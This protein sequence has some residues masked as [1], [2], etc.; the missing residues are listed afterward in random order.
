[1]VCDLKSCKLMS[2]QMICS[3]SFLYALRRW[4]MI[5]FTIGEPLTF[6]D[7]TTRFVPL[8]TVKHTLPLSGAY[9]LY[10]VCIPWHNIGNIILRYS[11]EMY[12][13]S[14]LV[15]YLMC[16]GYLFSPWKLASMASVRGVNVPM[17]TTLRRTTVVFTM[18]MEYIMAGQRYTSPVVG[19]WP[20]YCIYHLYV[21][22]L[23]LFRIGSC[24]FNV[25]HSPC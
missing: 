10:M 7:N 9:L 23:I 21:D 14:Y 1:M 12:I 6:S 8:K 17:Y 3:C 11:L 13:Y 25:V 24:F 15:S 16:T 22:V 4:R 5:S 18:I 20:L 19:R 2:L